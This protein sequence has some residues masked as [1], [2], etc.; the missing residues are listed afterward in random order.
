MGDPKVAKLVPNMVK[1]TA[2]NV[3]GIEMEVL[4]VKD[5]EEIE[6]ELEEEM[7]ERCCKKLACL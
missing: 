6:H 2:E 7:T 4:S 3:I 1:V 5:W